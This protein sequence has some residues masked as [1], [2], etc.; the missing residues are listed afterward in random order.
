MDNASSRPDVE[1][2]CKMEYTELYFMMQDISIMIMAV[3]AFIV[4]FILILGEFLSNWWTNRNKRR[5]D[6]NDG[7]SKQ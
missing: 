7:D 2:R 6:S 1:R 4:V 3:V 5:G